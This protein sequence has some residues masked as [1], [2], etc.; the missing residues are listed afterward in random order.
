MQ[1]ATVNG[2]KPWLCTVHYYSDDE[3]NFY[4]A[5][6]LDREHSEHIKQNPNVTAYVLVHENEFDGDYV[7]GIS[8][9]GIAELIGPKIDP[10]NGTAYVKKLGKK[11]NILTEIASGQNSHQFYRLKPTRIVLFDSKNFPDEPRQEVVL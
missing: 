9:T 10:A 8:I 11:P 3:L 5:S 4:W 2:D 1:L 6:R 7:T